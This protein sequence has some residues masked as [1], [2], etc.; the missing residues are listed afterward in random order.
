MR[1]R[2][3]KPAFVSLLRVALVLAAGVFGLMML[4]YNSNGSRPAPRRTT[5][6]TMAVI[7]QALRAYEADH[8]RLPAALVALQA[9]GNMSYLDPDKKL[10][11]AWGR[12]FV[13]DPHPANGHEY[14]LLSKGRD[15]RL[16]T[17]D[18]LDAWTADM[19]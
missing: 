15:G 16:G 1:R 14:Q 6:A 13:Y 9:G 12:A 18:D 8:G 11:D 19:N 3:V 2:R 17:S 4:A 10:A 5:R 7:Q